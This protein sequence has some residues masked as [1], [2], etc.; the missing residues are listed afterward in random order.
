[1]KPV[2]WLLVGDRTGDNQQA[3]A[4]AGALPWPAVRKYV[5]VREPFAT[6]KPR[7]VPSIQH[8]DLG[9]SD[10]LAPPWPDLVVTMGRRLS[11]VALWIRAQAAREA[12]PPRVRIVLVG[13][14]SG[15]DADF[16][17]IVISAETPLPP[18]RNTVP[19][20]LPLL[21]VDPAAVRA[22]ALAWRGELGGGTSPRLALLVGGPTRPFRFGLEELGD[23]VDA[24]LQRVAGAN[25]SLVVTTSPR[26]PRAFHGLLRKRLAGRAW[27]H[28]FARGAPRNPYLGLLG[29]ADEFV[30]TADSVSMLV[31]VARLA[32]PLAIYP[33][34]RARP[35][36]ATRLSRLAAGRL[37]PS[38]GAPA[39][40]RALAP[41]GYALY[42]AG[43]IRHSRDFDA[44]HSFLV[45]HDLA[46]WW[47]D[48]FSRGGVPAPDELPAI[49][50]RI[51]RLME[52]G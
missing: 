51:E 2:V 38:T 19:I 1:V 29:T 30:V 4:V 42:R 49:V 16:D 21:R 15:R 39:T 33:L 27:L 44:I 24:V 45:D 8:L 35:R 32:K 11:M 48:G 41:L 46:A 10:A 31:E 50:R 9:A 3:Q 28:C 18:Q 6:R 36:T 17:L 26:T 5:R 25:G 12:R 40:T 13:K 37:L 14:P 52:T 34:P 43:F 22:E 20:G 7:V 23:L 47:R